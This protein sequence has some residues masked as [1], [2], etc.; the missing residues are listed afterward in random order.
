MADVKELL[1][2]YLR[3]QR[4]H[5]LGILEGLDE[6]QLRR[7]VL[8]SG[9]SCLGLVH[10][11]TVDDER[12]WFAAVVAGDPAAIGELADDPVA[13]WQV[14]DDMSVDEVLDGYRA[15]CEQSDAIVAARSLDDAPAWWPDFFADFRMTDLHDVLLHVIAETATHAGH[16]DAAREL[17]DG[18]QWMVLGD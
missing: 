13:A 3:A 18:R 16:L 9:W 14:P 5:V 7:P 2:G 11:L 10:H 12:F 1:M 17:I 6:E 15:V 8:P 4:R